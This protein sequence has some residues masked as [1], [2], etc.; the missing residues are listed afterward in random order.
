MIS[1][2][3]LRH[4]GIGHATAATP[5]LCSDVAT[6]SRGVDSFIRPAELLS[7]FLQ[8]PAE[9]AFT[10]C[11]S[12]PLELSRRDD[13]DAIESERLELTGKV[14][15]AKLVLRPLKPTRPVL[16]T[17]RT[18]QPAHRLSFHWV[19]WVKSFSFNHAIMDI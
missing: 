8:I 6:A 16:E 13:Q 2:R 10:E 4:L 19:A 14:S 18:A 11:L 3:S 9:S 7:R 5:H 12:Q 1:R 15:A 17:Y